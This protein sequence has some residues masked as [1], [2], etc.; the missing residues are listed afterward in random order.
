[1]RIFEEREDDVDILVEY[2]DCACLSW[3]EILNLIDD[4]YKVNSFLIEYD[5]C[6]YEFYTT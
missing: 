5:V 2:D 3:K 6:V 4:Y 1:M